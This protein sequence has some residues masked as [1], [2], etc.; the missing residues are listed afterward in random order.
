[1]ARRLAKALVIVRTILFWIYGY[2]AT[3]ILLSPPRGSRWAGFAFVLV[4]AAFMVLR[5]LILGLPG[6][7]P[8]LVSYI[9]L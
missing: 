3:A 8:I 5:G 7:T 6:L 4:I 2:L 1:M 9:F